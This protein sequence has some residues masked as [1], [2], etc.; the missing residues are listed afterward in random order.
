MSRREDITVDIYRTL[1]NADDPRFG[2]V[3]R[4]PFDAQQLSR[5]QF[6]A[7]Y[8]TT[9]DEDRND[10]S[11]T[12][13]GLRESTMNVVLTAWVNGKNVDT[14]R[15]DVIERVEEALEADRTRGGI[16]RWTQL[17]SVVVDFDV[18]EPF[19]SVEITVEVYYTYQ[20]GQA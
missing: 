17:R 4:E 9:A 11:M 15:N 8:I 2:L 18:V 1:L 3:S 14:L 12:P 16:A 10:L 5:Q 6:P 19:G 7:V 13:T 20:R